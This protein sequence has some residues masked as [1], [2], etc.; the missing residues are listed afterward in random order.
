[1]FLKVQFLGPL[2]FN[3]FLND[4]FYFIKVAKLSNYGD[5]NQLYSS[6]LKPA[7]AEETMK[8]ELQIASRWFSNNHLIF[9]PDKCKAMVISNNAQ[10]DDLIFTIDRKPIPKVDSLELLGTIVDKSLYF[11]N[12]I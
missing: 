8:E 4:I 5:D 1:M 2:F 3:V 9:N 6:D 11:S 10:T 7:V 12:H